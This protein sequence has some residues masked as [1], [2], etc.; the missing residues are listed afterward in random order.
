MSPFLVG[1]EL[2]L[3]L[4]HLQPPPCFGIK[5]QVFLYPTEYHNH[6]VVGCKNAKNIS[7]FY[8][9]PSLFG[10]RSLFLS[11]P[12]FSNINFLLKKFFFSFFFFFYCK[13]SCTLQNKIQLPIWIT[14]I[15]VPTPS[16]YERQDCSWQ[17]TLTVC[18]IHYFGAIRARFSA[19][20]S[21]QLIPALSFI[22][23]M[24]YSCKSKKG[25]VRIPKCM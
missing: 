24:K 15:V 12:H 17:N 23:P 18:Y 22:A 16:K 20:R 10:P 3:K 25:S 5:S 6:L 8:N 19:S 14:F 11:C 2:A 9:S 21:D 4:Q 7:K 13:P 1:M